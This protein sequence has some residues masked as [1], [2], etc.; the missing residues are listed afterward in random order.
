MIEDSRLYVAEPQWHTKTKPTSV[1]MYCF[2]G[3]TDEARYH[4]ILTGEVYLTDGKEHYCLNCALK[5]GL[6]TQARPVLSE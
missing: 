1:K 5:K 6:V 2:L 4:R 3:D